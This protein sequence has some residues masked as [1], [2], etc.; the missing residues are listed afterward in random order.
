M[1]G[2]HNAGGC[3]CCGCWDCSVEPIGIEIDAGGTNTGGEDCCLFPTATY[4]RTTTDC[5]E[6]W[7]S[8]ENIWGITGGYDMDTGCYDDL[9]Y[10][11]AEQ[12]LYETQLYE[13]IAICGTAVSYDGCGWL[14]LGVGAM[15]DG[16]GGRPSTTYPHDHGW[17]VTLQLL[18]GKKIKVTVERVYI[19]AQPVDGYDTTVTPCLRTYAILF[20]ATGTG[21][22]PYLAWGYTVDIYEYT[23]TDC[24]DHVASISH[25]SRTSWW[26]DLISNTTGS[27]DTIVI[28]DG[29][30][31][32]SFTMCDYIPSVNVLWE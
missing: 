13:L 27:D 16:N 32:Y 31:T 29:T 25:T 28:D 5:N 15:Y 8:D 11:V 2:K 6:T 7:Y 17:K 1:P 23:L 30:N 19:V 24:D 10:G 20:G 9:C 12:Y 4:L 14:V 22:H 18:T 21:G 3:K 26:K